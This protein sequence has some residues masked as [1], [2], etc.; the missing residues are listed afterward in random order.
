MGG[1]FFVVC[2]LVRTTQSRFKDKDGAQVIWKQEEL[3]VFKFS[4]G[5]TLRNMGRNGRDEGAKFSR[6]K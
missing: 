4:W 1:W 2:L 3:D 6:Y 5:W